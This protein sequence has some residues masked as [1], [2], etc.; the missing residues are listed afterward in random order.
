MKFHSFCSENMMCGSVT[1]ITYIMVY[2]NKSFSPLLQI[3]VSLEWYNSFLTNLHWL[4]LSL[5]LS[6][7]S[8]PTDSL[9]QQFSE[10]ESM[11][12]VL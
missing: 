2:G 12:I 8:L 11:M 1:Y 4:L 10:F 9:S 5:L 6:S 3:E 7:V